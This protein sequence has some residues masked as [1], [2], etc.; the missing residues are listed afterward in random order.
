MFVDGR[1]PVQEGSQQ[2]NQTTHHQPQLLVETEEGTPYHET[3]CHCLSPKQPRGAA[4]AMWV[5]VILSLIFILQHVSLQPGSETA[6]AV[7]PDIESKNYGKQEDNVSTMTPRINGRITA[8]NKFFPYKHR[9]TLLFTKPKECARCFSS[10]PK[11]R[12]RETSPGELQAGCCGNRITVKI[13]Q[14]INLAIIYPG[15][16]WQERLLQQPMLRFT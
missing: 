15:G 11:E 6:L 13:T 7:T 1:T 4:R 8:S 3:R 10:M 2:E 12:M 16:T 5:I 9:W 14:V